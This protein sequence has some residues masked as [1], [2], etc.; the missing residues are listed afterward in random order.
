MPRQ[1]VPTIKYA[2]L[3]CARIGAWKTFTFDFTRQPG[4]WGG[5]TREAVKRSGVVIVAAFQEQ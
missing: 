2:A 3:R 5:E 1:T 4:R